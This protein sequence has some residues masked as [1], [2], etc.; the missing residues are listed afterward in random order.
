MPFSVKI[1]ERKAAFMRERLTNR[2]LKRGFSQKER[3]ALQKIFLYEGRN[4]SEN[5]VGYFDLKARTEEL[6]CA[7]C[8]H[9]ALRDIFL[10]FCLRGSGVYKINLR[11]YQIAVLEMLASIKSGAEV[12]FYAAE[13]FVL[14]T[15]AQAKKA[16]RS[17]ALKDIKG[18]EFFELKTGKLGILISAERENREDEKIKTEHLFERC[19]VVDAFIGKEPL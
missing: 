4:C 18:T 10:S 17:K 14:I 11:L 9:L 5:F 19:S 2:I 15:A 13:N 8:L 16:P 6:F 3:R 12:S 7:A 1:H